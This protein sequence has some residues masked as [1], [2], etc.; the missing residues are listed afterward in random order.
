MIKA[1]PRAARWTWLILLVAIGVAFLLHLKLHFYQPVYLAGI[2]PLY[3]LLLAYGLGSLVRRPVLMAMALLI[4]PLLGFTLQNYY[5][6]PAFAKEDWRGIGRYMEKNLQTPGTM[7]FHKSWLKAPLYYYFPVELVTYSLPDAAQSPD[8]PQ[9]QE[10]KA[11]L[12]RYPKVWLILG[13]NFDTG[14]YYRKLL[15][16]WFKEGPARAFTTD[17]TIWVVEYFP[18]SP[19][20]GAES[21]R[22]QSKSP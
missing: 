17:R 15:A 12:S 21:N 4:F 14:D 7:V 19:P 9:L 8:S 13:H 6:N 11:Q 18:G 16:S 2:M 10:I 5:F 3:L 20:D 22:P 1:D